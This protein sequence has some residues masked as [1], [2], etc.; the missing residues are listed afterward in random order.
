MKFLSFFDPQTRKDFILAFYCLPGIALIY[1]L[2]LLLWDVEHASIAAGGAV[3]AGYGANKKLVHFPFAPMFIAVIGMS[4]MTYLG[5]WLGQYFIVVVCVGMLLGA[6]CALIALVDINAWWILLQW[7]ISFFLAAYYAH[8][9]YTAIIR[10]LLILLG[11]L[12]QTGIMMFLLRKTAL[13]RNIIHPRNIRIIIHSIHKNIDKKVRFDAAGIYGALAMLICFAFISLSQIH[14]HYWASMTVILILKPDFKN[15]LSR[16]QNRLTGTFVGILLAT[17][18][19]LFNLSFSTLGLVTLGAL[20]FCYA[21]CNQQYAILTV[22][23][24]VATVLMFSMEGTSSWYIAVDRIIATSV[25]GIS[26]LIVMIFRAMVLMVI[27]QMNK[28]EWQT[29]HNDNP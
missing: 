7:A 15:T 13:R 20:Y 26:A 5:S 12:T 2:G 19:T 28:P 22:F 25:G 29:K 21:L 27:Q 18:I 10:T 24:T 4:V 9:T 3:A 16:A 14:Y 17:G 11:G 23:I 6:L 1:I 8:D